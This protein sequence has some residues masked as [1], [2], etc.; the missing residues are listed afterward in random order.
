[1]RL[2]ERSATV[3][4]ELD[5]ALDAMATGALGPTE[6][7]DE[8]LRLVLTAQRL[9]AIDRHSA[10]SS[11]SGPIGRFEAIVDRSG[12][13]ARQSAP[14][15]ARTGMLMRPRRRIDFGAVATAAVLVLTLLGGFAVFAGERAAGPAVVDPAVTVYR[16]AD[17]GLN[18]V[19]IDPVTLLDL[20]DASALVSATPDVNW[21]PTFQW[22]PDLQA[23]TS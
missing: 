3:A 12:S 15:S 8:A 20:P 4:S 19:P 10:E 5:R 2:P 13:S 9:Q 1:M 23:F 14:P 7:G 16:T 21:S 11:Q 18:L 6:P 17:D 22:D